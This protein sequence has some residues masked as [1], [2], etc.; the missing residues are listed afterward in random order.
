MDIREEVQ[1][2]DREKVVS[3]Y[4]LADR[5]EK[6]DLSGEV[7]MRVRVYRTGES[8]YEF[9]WSRHHILMDGWCLSILINEFNAL[10]QGKVSGSEV[11]LPPVEP[12]G[13]YIDWLESRDESE[14]RR[15]WSE[16][17]EGL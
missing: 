15:Y 9:I 13:K 1:A 12:Y 6:F 5:S 10:Y 14:G 2:G 11:A 16:Y 17:L 7:P 3:A 8:E 4:R